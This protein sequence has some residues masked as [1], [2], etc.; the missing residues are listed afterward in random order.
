MTLASEPAGRPV[1][2]AEARPRALALAH[3]I[4]DAGVDVLVVRDVLGRFTLIVD[5]RTRPLPPALE[6]PEAGYGPRLVR[7]LGRYA[8]D[9]PLMAAS[10]L[11][12]AD[13]LLG[14]ERAV[15]DPERPGGRVRILDNTVVGEDWAQVSTPAPEADGSRTH[16][17]ALYGFKGG[18]GRS[19]ATAVLARHLADQGHIV[20]VVDLD[21]ESPGV[22]PLVAEGTELP[23]HGVIDLLVESAVGNAEGLDHV[24]RTGYAPRGG[25]GELWVSP[26]RGRGAPGVPYAYV[27][28]LNRAYADVPG[29]DFADRL[30]QAVR[31]CEEAVAR[32]GESGRR[33]DVVLLDSRAGIH[34]IAAVIISRLC[35][36]ALLFG[37]DNA[38]TWEGYGDL[39]EAW[40]TSGQAPAVRDKLR[41]VASMVPDSPLRPQGAYLQSFREH[42]WECFALLY[43]DDVVDPETNALDPD[44][45]S[46]FLEDESAPHHPIPILF[47]PG[48]VGLDAVTAPGW[49]DRAFVQAAY[50]D[51]LPTATLLITAD[52]QNSEGPR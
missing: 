40:L 19:T 6:D 36:L 8:A 32:D 52:P 34:D 37:T 29:A 35:D 23:A 13:G 45:F 39:F 26:A 7:E 21:L 42:A 3:E 50:R 1:R 27:E 17:T 41:M 49:Q 48:L 51:F 5:D 12:S 33:P 20:L 24:V 25:R 47:E 28:K 44:T 4:A 14:S 18:V 22:G 43:D 46:P 38:Q 2:F 9:R 31:A 15:K 10:G 30:E 11:F 16:R